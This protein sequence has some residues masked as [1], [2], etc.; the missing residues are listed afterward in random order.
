[1]HAPQYIV[2]ELISLQKSKENIMLVEF[3]YTS[4]VP[5]G[6]IHYVN[7][8]GHE[9][10]IMLCFSQELSS[11]IKPHTY[12]DLVCLYNVRHVFVSIE[13]FYDLVSNCCSKPS[14]IFQPTKNLVLI[15]LFVFFIQ[16]KFVFKMILT[17]KFILPFQPSIN[18][19]HTQNTLFL[20]KNNNPINIYLPT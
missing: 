7:P 5:S 1:M 3:N 19:K 10:G 2:N 12:I 20:R 8:F 18:R 17:L 9:C 13:G 4:L 6:S 16:T 14:R 15:K 11:M